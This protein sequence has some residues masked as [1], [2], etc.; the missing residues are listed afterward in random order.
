MP[1]QNQT[2]TISNA[3][4]V[5]PNG[6]LENGIVRVVDGRIA[7]IGTWS[8]VADSDRMAWHDAA[9]D[10]QGGWLLPGFIDLHVHGGYGADF[11]DASSEAYDTITKFHMEQGTT[12]MLATSMTQSHEA[13]DRVM[14][15]VD[16]Y[17][18]AGMKFAQLAGVHL[19]GPFV[20]PIFKGAQNPEYMIDPQISWLEDWH[21]RFSGLMKQLT[22][23][24]ERDG[25]LEA[26]RWLRARGINAAAGHTAAT[27]DEMTLAANA[28]MNQAVHTFN[29]M[30]GLH[31]R[32]PGTA[33]AT[34]TDD[35]IVAE[36]IADGIHV[37]PACVK[38]LTR[39]KAP[40]KLVLI[41][42]AMSAAGLGNG[43][44]DLGGLA[45]TVRDGV[46]RL[47]EGGAL[48]GSTLTMIEAV[49][50][51][52]AF[53]GLSVPEVSVLASLNPAQHIGIADKTGS[54]E[55]GKQADLVWTDADLN[56][57]RVWVQ[58]NSHM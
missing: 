31:H 9:I 30:T 57:Q 43:E 8:Q 38:L 53:T 50:N 32:D 37:H 45:V 58:G 33:G 19:E 7:F 22:L 27:F 3:R 51:V 52:I 55:V 34:M 54:I 4:V 17:Q 18:Q 56:V 2:F 5:T 20:N 1:N 39:A 42:D 26:I 41:T 25:A 14:V 23:A 15:A 47:T 49:K 36:V 29:A 28:G 24:P 35:R 44:Y 46:C 16:A 10:A 21:A 40:G 13:L 6:T 48:A 12:A 11:M